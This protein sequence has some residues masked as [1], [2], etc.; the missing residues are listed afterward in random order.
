[1]IILIAVSNTSE[2]CNVPVE[3]LRVPGCC[4]SASHLV[5]QWFDLHKS[6]GH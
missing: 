2:L 3:E 6:K 4:C 5:C 1:M